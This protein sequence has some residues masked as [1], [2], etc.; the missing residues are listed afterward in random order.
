M[1]KVSARAVFIDI[2]KT[3][4]ICRYLAYTILLQQFIEDI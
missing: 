4:I 1:G 2:V 3:A